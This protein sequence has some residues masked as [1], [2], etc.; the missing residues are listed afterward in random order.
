MRRWWLVYRL[1]RVRGTVH[2][3][4]LE[5]NSGL[6]VTMEY[7]S[8]STSCLK[9]DPMMLWTVSI[10]H[11]IHGGLNRAM[12]RQDI[13]WV[14][15]C[16]S[17]ITEWC[18]LRTHSI[19]PNGEEESEYSS[20]QFSRDRLKRR[21]EKWMHKNSCCLANCQHARWSFV[22]RHSV[23]LCKCKIQLAPEYFLRVALL[24]LL[25]D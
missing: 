8:L 16:G 10:R 18:R 21:L 19:W 1:S 6:L 12:V 14:Q 22:G 25:H 17:E 15:D 3:R 7:S 9:E 4:S 24:L 5:W 23:Y 20:V 2:D 11:A 13:D